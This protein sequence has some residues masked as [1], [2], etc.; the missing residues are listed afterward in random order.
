MAMATMIRNMTSRVNLCSLHNSELLQREVAI[1]RHRSTEDYVDGTTVVDQCPQMSC[2]Q[3]QAYYL[4]EL[5]ASG[6]LLGFNYACPRKLKVTKS[7][8][9]KRVG[10]TPSQ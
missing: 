4:S 1:N 10:Q 3:P 7:V 8:E 9:P 6:S 5:P 2:S